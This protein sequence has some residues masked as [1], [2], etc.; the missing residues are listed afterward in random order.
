MSSAS[1]R[2][3]LSVAHVQFSH[4][5]PPSPPSPTPSS[6]PENTTSPTVN[7]QTGG[8]I[9]AIDMSW[10]YGNSSSPPSLALVFLALCLSVFDLAV[11]LSRL[12]RPCHGVPVTEGEWG[13]GLCPCHGCRVLA[14]ILSLPCPSPLRQLW[15]DRIRHLSMLST[16]AILLTNR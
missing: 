10:K 12:P 3:L 5:S 6:W 8:A 7:I 2:P 11:S 1:S 4:E 16:I 15:T 9:E 14:F 13:G